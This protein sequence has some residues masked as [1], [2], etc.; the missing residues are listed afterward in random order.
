MTKI[1][2][3]STAALLLFALAAC[4]RREPAT[5]TLAAGKAAP[6]VGAIDNPIPTP[7]AESVAQGKGSPRTARVDRRARAEFKSIEGIKLHGDAKLE[8]TATGVLIHVSVADAPPGKKGIHIHEKGDCSDIPG[9]SM[10]SHFNPGKVEHGL[11]GSSQ[12]HPGDLGNIVIDKDG[13]GA[14]DITTDQGGLKPD[15]PSS[16]LGR[17]IVI[18]ESDDKGVQPT[19]GAGKPIACAVV[20]PIKEAL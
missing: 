20:E 5:D 6:T 13:K 12:H 14:L 4:N 7:S 15:E 8:E 3:S 10:G 18:H 11:P 2:E 9:S 17:A 16:F 19:G 1:L